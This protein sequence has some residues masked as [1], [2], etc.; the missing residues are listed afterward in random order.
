METT[1]P[2]VAARPLAALRVAARLGAAALVTL[3][4]WLAIFGGRLALLGRRR[5]AD[6]WAHRVASWWGRRVGA[7]FG[8]RTEVAGA[9]PPAP[10]LLVANHLS[11]ID[12]PLLLGAAGGTFVAKREIASWPVVGHLCRLIGVVFIDRASRRDVRRVADRVAAGLAAGKG[13]VV[14]PEGT[15]GDGRELLPF[16]SS[17]LEVA[18]ARRLPVHWAT[19]AYATDGDLPAASEVVCWTG[20]APL[21]PHA[22]RLLA[23]P[24]FRTRV[25]FGAEP[26]ADGDRKRLTERLRDAMA[27]DL[28]ARP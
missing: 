8:S 10:F 6:A 23:M 21:L 22:L 1:H 25:A 4:G 11:W 24:G 13:V 7:I 28:E 14:F 17:L 19:L 20:G 9:P 26:L 16:R 18:A 12:V 3:A 2:T 15:T 27:A 5:R